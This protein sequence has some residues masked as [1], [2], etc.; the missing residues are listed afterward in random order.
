M[1]ISTPRAPKNTGILS[2]PLSRALEDLYTLVGQPVIEKLR[3]LRR[4]PG[5]VRWCTTSTF[6]VP[7]HAMGPI[8]LD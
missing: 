7:L 2:V 1:K 6:G 3:E 5:R 4:I 8:F